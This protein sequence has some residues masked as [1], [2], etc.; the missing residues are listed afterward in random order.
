MEIS[1]LDEAS[2]WT[3]ALASDTP[4]GVVSFAAFYS[5]LQKE[6]PERC[7]DALLPL[8]PESINSHAVVRHCMMRIK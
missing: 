4:A 3:E 7:L 5:R 1:P 6:A 2:N 8:I